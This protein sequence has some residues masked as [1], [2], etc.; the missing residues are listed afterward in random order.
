VASVNEEFKT[1]LDEK[2]KELYQVRE[3]ASR[4][5]TE[6]RSRNVALREEF[7]KLKEEVIGLRARLRRLSGNGTGPL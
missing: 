4:E 6:E 5:I 7:A 2:R 3:E 1:Q